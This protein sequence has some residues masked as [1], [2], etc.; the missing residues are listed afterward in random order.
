MVIVCAL[1]V[2][3]YL[4]A[5]IIVYIKT[6]LTP[7]KHHDSYYIY[8]CYILYNNDVCL[9]SRFVTVDGFATGVFV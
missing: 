9:M 7:P 3:Y 1:Q 2:P 8:R 4:L 6:E 5:F